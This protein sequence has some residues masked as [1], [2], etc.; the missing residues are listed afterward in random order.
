[1]LPGCLEAVR[2]QVGGVPETLLV[3]NGSRDGSLAAAQATWPGLAVLANGWNRGFAGGMNAGIRALLARPTPP[4]VLVLLNQDTLVARDW[5]TKLVMPFEEESRI[6]AVGCKIYYPDG[7]TLQH[8]GADVQE[9]RLFGRHIGW[10]ESDQGQ[11]DQP[12]DV[13]YVTGAAVALRS[14]ALREVGLFDEGFNPAYYEEVELCLR[15]RRGGYRV[16]FTPFATLRH[17]ESASLS[18]PLERAVI[19]NRSRL[20]FAVK[21]LPIEQLLDVFFPAEHAALLALRGFPHGTE[22]RALRLSLLEALARLPEWLRARAAFQG[23][24]DDLY[25]AIRE[26]LIRLYGVLR[27]TA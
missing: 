15:L 23:R 13:A 19:M 3:D 1:M 4:D 10:H 6:G 12:R 9:P 17:A 24:N 14:A 27:Y 5:F 20:R 18:D 22:A 2:A 7:R 11:Y 25:G 26:W 16:H 8:A 21:T